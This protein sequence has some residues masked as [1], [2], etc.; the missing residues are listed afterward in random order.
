MKTWSYQEARDKVL[1]DLD[2]AE[3]NF[4]TPP[5]L[6]GYFNEAIDEAEAEILKLNEDYFLR[7]KPFVFVTGQDT[8]GL[9]EDIYA[10]KIRGFTYKSGGIHYDIPRFRDY[11]KFERIANAQLY[12]A[13]DEYQ[14]FVKN[15]SASEGSKIVIIPAS[16]EDGPAGVLWYI[17]NANRVPQLGEMT[18]PEDFLPAAVDT[19][20]EKITVT[21]NFIVDD[22]VTFSSTGVLPAG[23]SSTLGYYVVDASGGQIQ[24]SDTIGGAPVDLTDTGT[25]TH[26]VKVAATQTVTDETPIDIPEFIAFIFQFV[27]V[28]CLEKE[29]H[30]N[31]ESAIAILGQQRKM[32]VDTLTQM[33]PDNDDEI[34]PDMSHYTEHS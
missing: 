18:R 26:T 21:G 19:V 10:H 3:E 12:G 28:R 23:L 29:G 30:P 7:D 15:P 1:V 25:G 9:P 4:I 34:E 6:I 16:R 22:L 2:L 31:Y 13:S 20:F 32:L 11:R 8:Y 24:V 33:I 14:Y 27:K 5:E 17:R